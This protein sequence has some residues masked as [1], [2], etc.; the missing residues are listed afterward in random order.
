M[1]TETLS[2]QYLI[3]MKPVPS[4]GDWREPT[5]TYLHFIFRALCNNQNGYERNGCKKSSPFAYENI[6]LILFEWRKTMEIS[7]ESQCT[8]TS[9]LI[10]F[11][12]RVL[13]TSVWKEFESLHPFLQTKL[14]FMPHNHIST[15]KRTAKTQNA[16]TRNSSLFAPCCVSWL[17]DGIWPSKN[18]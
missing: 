11:I 3:Y 9:K 4:L 15:A 7:R 10:L 14:H 12:F 5:C 18:K 16:L 6:L 2:S 13:R 8:P 17:I 1:D